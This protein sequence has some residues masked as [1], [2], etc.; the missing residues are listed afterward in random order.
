MEQQVSGG[1]AYQASAAP[2]GQMKTGRGLLKFI[3]LNFVTLG[4]YSL[5]YFSGISSD[6]NTIASRYDGKRTMHFCLLAFIVGPITFGI[7]F[8]VWYHKLSDRIGKELRRR[9][10]C[11][12]F[13][14][15]DF[16]LWNVVG[17][18]IL[19]GPFVYLHKLSKAM[20]KIAE[21]YNVNG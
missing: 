3:L 19:V 9:G 13:S 21:H 1:S 6:I 10:I 11:Y 12:S 18:I 17:S 16:W 15:A 4:I 20:N 5:V 7:A 2:V 8:I 14:A